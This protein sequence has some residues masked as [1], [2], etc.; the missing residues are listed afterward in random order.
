VRGI[1][2]F[3]KK[4][5]LLF[6]EKTVFVVGAG[7]SCELKMPSGA[8]L[9]DAIAAGAKVG[10]GHYDEKATGDSGLRVALQ[11]HYDS[12]AINERL[13]AMRNIADGIYL[14]ESIDN[15]IERHQ[16]SSFVAEMGKFIIA[17]FLLK[18]EASSRLKLHQDRDR[19][20]DLPSLY[21]T[22]LDPFTRTLISGLGKGDVDQIGSEIAIVCFNYDRCIERYLQDAIS[23][24]FHLE[25]S[26]ADRIVR[27]IRIL[28]P[29]GSLGRLPPQPRGSGDG[30][31][32]FGAPPD[33]VD[34]PSVARRLR[35]YTEQIDDATL[36]ADVQNTV[37]EAKQ[38][39]FL[40]FGFHQQNIKLLTGNFGDSVPAKRVYYSGYGIPDQAVETMIK[41]T[42]PLAGLASH[43]I[44]KSTHFE[45]NGTAHHVMSVYRAALSA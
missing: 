34:L 44:A 20:L 43:H 23:R 11:R 1:Q 18:A 3:Q 41:R 10:F 22:W 36:I 33:T 4:A 38:L 40:G 14:A 31:V 2:R 35:T 19:P 30:L 28:R 7:A 32:P 13:P 29:Y 45:K 26:H 16:D 27:N 37:R 9:T 15:Y 17:Y 5:V 8:Q 39:V 24:A 42:L 6:K 21:D 25:P 12:R